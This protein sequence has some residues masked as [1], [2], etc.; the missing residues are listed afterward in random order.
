MKQ[1]GKLGT[2]D[3]VVVVDKVQKM[4]QSDGMIL[5]EK[6]AEKGRKEGLD[7]ILCV[8]VRSGSENNVNV[9]IRP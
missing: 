4:V 3:V 6:K 8:C 2:C 9:Q 5:I 1:R 7:A